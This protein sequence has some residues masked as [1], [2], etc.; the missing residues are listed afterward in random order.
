M[1]N[2]KKGSKGISPLIA[3]VLLIAF[4]IAMAA[5]IGN[6]L[7]TF[8]SS[9]TDTI[10]DKSDEELR[11]LYGGVTISDL[12]YC[13]AERNISG[14]VMNTRLVHLGSIA[15]QIFFDNGSSVD[16]HLNNSGTSNSMTLEPGEQDLFSD[17]KIGS[18][19]DKLHL[20]TNCSSVYADATRGDVVQSCS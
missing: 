4:T 5:I 14:T 12:Q 11:C 3:T 16:F 20:R 8:T 18:N 10:T 19:Y 2:Y 15:L 1:R 9:H 17:L 13:D 7:P 6:W